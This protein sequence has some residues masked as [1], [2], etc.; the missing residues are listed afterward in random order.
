MGDGEEIIS[1]HLKNF[2]AAQ[3]PNLKNEEVDAEV[4]IYSSSTGED[5]VGSTSLPLV[6]VYLDTCR[7]PGQPALQNETMRS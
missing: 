1:N 4:H 2:N 3:D 6:K 7:V 5:E